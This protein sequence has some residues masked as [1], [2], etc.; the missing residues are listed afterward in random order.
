MMTIGE[1]IGFITPLLIV[2]FCTWKTVLSLQDKYPVAQ[3]LGEKKKA[4]KMILTCAGVFP[5]ALHL[6][7]FSF[8][9]DFL[10]KSNEI[11]AA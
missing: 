7:S 9:L 8:P 10:V 2:L 4:L 1:L 5:L 6:L 3:D 11:K